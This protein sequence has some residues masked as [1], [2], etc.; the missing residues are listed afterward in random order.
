M[1]VVFILL[2]LAA[3]LKAQQQQPK[4]VYIPADEPL[5]DVLADA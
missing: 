5:L 2:A 4:T 1:H 3:A